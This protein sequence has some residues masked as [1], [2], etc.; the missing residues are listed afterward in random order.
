MR[1][2]KAGSALSSVDELP[3]LAVRT[4][5]LDQ[6]TYHFTGKLQMNRAQA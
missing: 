4:L 6:L 1:H 2:W 3:G 5:D